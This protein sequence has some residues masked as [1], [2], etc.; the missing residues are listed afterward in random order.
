M[1]KT[2]QQKEA[3]SQE[4]TKLELKKLMYIVLAK[5]LYNEGI[6]TL[7]ECNKAISEYR[8]MTK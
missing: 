4:Q 8:K 7:D 5:G 1:G 6:I 2:I 3:Q